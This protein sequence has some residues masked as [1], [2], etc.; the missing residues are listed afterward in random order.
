[1]KD[2]FIPYELALELKEIGF[3]EPCLGYYYFLSNGDKELILHEHSNSS[4]NSHYPKE[5]SAILWQQAFD[6]FRKEHNLHG[7]FRINQFG[8]GYMY[9]IISDKEYRSI[10]DLTGGVQYKWSYEKARL[11]CLQKLIEIVKNY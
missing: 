6:W 8:Y 1:M 7:D 9:S 3:N 5:I 4:I 2:Q 11:A 10:V